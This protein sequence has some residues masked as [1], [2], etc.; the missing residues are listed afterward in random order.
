[1]NRTATLL[2]ALIL[3]CGKTWGGEPATPWNDAILAIIA[4][5]PS[6][7][8]YS[9]GGTANAALRRAVTI[10]EGLIRVDAGKANPSYCSEAT[11]LVFLKLLSQLD[12]QHRISL[13]ASLAKALQPGNQTDGS[14]IWGRWNANGPGT[15]VLFHEQNLGTSFLDPAMARP[16]DFLKIFWNDGIGASEHG[17]SVI[18]LGTEKKGGTTCLRFWSSNLPNG[19]GEKTVPIAKARRLL[20]SR[21][22]HPERIRVPEPW[23]DR[24]LSSLIKTS[25]GVSE[26][27]ARSGIRPTSRGATLPPEPL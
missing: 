1:M 18:F 10:R 24:Y 2:L 23:T 3:L 11:Y 8:I 21:L 25:S 5:M 9:A 20:F 7:G 13:D 17:H 4:G 26:M 27:E 6:G 15:A 19:Y 22:E 16:G 12:G 14:G